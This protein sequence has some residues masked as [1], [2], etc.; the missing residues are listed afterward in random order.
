MAKYS[1]TFSCGHEGRVDV[2]GPTKNRQWIV[3]R[4]FEGMC[5]ECY[6]IH[7][8]EQREKANIEASEKAKE[9]EL[10]ILQGSDKQV[11]WANTLRQKLIDK[12]ESKIKAVGERK[13]VNLEIINNI[14]QFILTNK[15]NAKWF[16]DNRFDFDNVETVFHNI[17]KE[18]DAI[19][20]T[21]VEEIEGKESIDEGIVSPVEVKHVGIVKIIAKDEK[22]LV[23]YDKNEEFRQIVK[24]LNFKWDGMWERKVNELTGNSTDRAAELGN[25]LLN[26]G[27]TISCIDENIRNKAVNGNYET[28]CDRWIKYNS[29]NNKLAIRWYDKNENMYG[30]AKNISTAKWNSDTKS[31]LVSTSHFEE[32]KDFAESYGFKFTQASIKAIEEYKTSLKK[33]KIVAPKVV[34]I[35]EPTDKIKEIL[36]SGSDIIDDLKD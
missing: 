30:K 35:E 6:E 34:I 27:F 19:A 17:K 22:I 16:I 12:V 20:I 21:Q 14:F 7:L 23:E 24:S 5:P 11:A 9:M 10:P 15:I 26:A 25:E 8:Q 33:A 1:G 18:M 4:K 3:D 2:V 31:I 32:V 36:D 13:G 29:D 28:E